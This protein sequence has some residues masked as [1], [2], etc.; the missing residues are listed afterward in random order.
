MKSWKKRLNEEFDKAA[1]ALNDEV[2]NAPIVTARTVTTTRATQ[3]ARRKGGWF[4]CGT[5]VAL[6]AIFVTL[7]V[8]G[9]FNVAPKADKFVFALD[10]NPSVSFV[11]DADGIV[12]GVQAQNA[13][14]DVV[15]SNQLLREQINGQ[16]LSEAIVAYTDYAVQLGYLSA[17]EKS[18]VR[19]STSNETD[20]KL[21]QNVSSSLSSYF[22]EH[23][24][25]AA[26]VEDKVPTSDL[27]ARF[28]VGATSLS[29]LSSTLETVSAFFAERNVSEATEEE[30][31]SLHDKFVDSD[32]VLKY[33]VMQLKESAR[34][35][36]DFIEYA[37]TMLLAIY[38]CNLKITLHED[39]PKMFILVGADYWEIK[40]NCDPSAFTD[41]FA[42]LMS[43]MDELIAEYESKFGKLESYDFF[44][45]LYNKI[46]DFVDSLKVI[47]NQL[48]ELAT[49]TIDDVQ[50]F[51]E[52]NFDELSCVG[53]D[54][55]GLEMLIAVP[56]TVEEYGSQLR[57]SWQQVAQ[58]KLESNKSVYEATRDAISDADYDAFIAGIEKNYGSLENFWQKIKK[59]Q[60]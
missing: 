52:D 50:Q 33:V 4:A 27:C 11:T 3:S 14:A 31:K 10:I 2:L 43:E 36:W 5:A 38:A 49:S 40:E 7:G 8:L 39:N 25:F 55:S 42:K 22:K 51:L 20:D 29:E 47:V 54:V 34:K 28:G 21:L 30:I 60:K 41:D 32:E 19:L 6:A 57:V 59:F 16:P 18:A 13:D 24:I 26:V 44:D 23:G 17:N 9:V 15:I 56:T 12:L 37:P 45:T 53:V 1:P 58:D 35:I 46:S 48:T